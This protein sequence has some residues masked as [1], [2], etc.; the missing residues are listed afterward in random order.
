[1]NIKLESFP[2]YF[3]VNGVPQQKGSVRVV[4]NGDNI[5]MAILGGNRQ[6]VAP[7]HF[8]D[9]ID[10]TDTPFA[11]KQDLLDAIVTAS[12]ESNAAGIQDAP[13]N[14]APYVR[15]NNA[16]I[17]DIQSKIVVAV[18]GGQDINQAGGLS[19]VLNPLVSTTPLINADFSF[20]P[21]DTFI[22]CL[23]A[24]FINISYNLIG[25]NQT[26]GRKNPGAIILKTPGGA[27]LETLSFSY[28][29]NTVDDVSQ[30]SIN[31]I[32]L[33]VDVNDQISLFALQLGSAGAILSVTGQS[34]LSVEYI[35]NV[36]L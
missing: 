34:F 32:Q 17:R 2:T 23:R 27:E 18:A 24:G 29:R 8:S 4:E 6:I 30:N 1:M 28:S 20:T 14:G 19:M 3:A 21:G 22:T 35:N 5:G 33:D 36:R 13:A 12:M 9:W 25:S 31:E 11:T 10:E 16:W 15:Q 7:N 26:G